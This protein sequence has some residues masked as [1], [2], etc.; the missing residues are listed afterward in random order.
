MKQ[1]NQEFIRNFVLV[2]ADKVANNAV[3]VCRIYYI[4]TL[5]QELDD[6]RAYQETDSDKISVV[7]AHFKIR[8]ACLSFLFVSTNAKTNFLRCIGY[9]SFKKDH[10]KLLVLVLPLNVLNYL[11]LHLSVAN[12][13]LSSKIYGKRDDF[14]FDIV[15]FPFLDGDVPCRS[16]YGLYTS[17]LIRFA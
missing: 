17:Q 6:T 7:N 11:D 2:P 3:V 13:F 16:S 4:N 15:N 1:G 8:I 14:D 9:L 12:G 5:K 10:I